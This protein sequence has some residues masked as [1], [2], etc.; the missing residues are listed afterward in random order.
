MLGVN[1]DVQEYRVN[2]CCSFKKAE[3]TWGP[4]SNLNTKYPFKFNGVQVHTSEALFQALRFPDFP[5]AQEL[6]LL[7]PSPLQAKTQAKKLLS[8]QSRKDFDEVKL[9]LMYWVLR[10]KFIKH[11][12]S[13]G[14]MFDKSGD[15]DIVEITSTDSYWGCIE[16]KE[17]KTTVRGQNMLGKLLM[18]LRSFYNDTKKT[19]EFMFI[20]PLDIE[21]FKFK[22]QPI[23]RIEHPV[24][25]KKYAVAEAEN[26]N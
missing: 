18:K 14:D 4:L 7:P 20:E 1:P 24:W 5:V 19:G 26:G 25:A 12:G 21:D 13:M 8:T 16:D 2:E 15:R 17:D 9:Q 22:G 23:G 10:V 11:Y 6:V 3:G